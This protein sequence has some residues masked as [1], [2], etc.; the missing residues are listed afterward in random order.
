[1]I[2]QLPQEIPRKMVSTETKPPKL[3]TARQ[4]G[5]DGTE[6]VVQQMAVLQVQRLQSRCRFSQHSLQGLL[7]KMSQLDPSQTQMF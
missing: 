6:L 5:Q 3:G 4:G 7:A 1:M 2:S